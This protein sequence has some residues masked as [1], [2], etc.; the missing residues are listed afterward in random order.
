MKVTNTLDLSQNK[1]VNLTDGVDD[2]D[3]ASVA[4][5][6]RAV[7]GYKYKEPVRVAT[8][9]SI[10]LSG[11][12][13]ID[14]VSVSAGDRVLVKDQTDAKENGVYIANS[15]VWS[16]S[17][18]FSNGGD[19]LG[20]AVFVSEGSDNGNDLYL[21]TTDAPVT[22]DTTDLV[23]TQIGGGI[24][25]TPG[26][27]INFDGTTIEIDRSLV[28]TKA[29]FNIG[30]AVATSFTVTHNFGTRDVVVSVRDNGTYAGVIA[31]WVALDVNSVQ[32]TFSRA[33]SA[34]QYRVIVMG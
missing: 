10:T 2:Q 22:V 4:Q 32:I 33:P 26:T 11:T 25:Y 5:L 9:E 31:D 16:R 7:K 13:V 8:T 34:A 18:D 6:N 12:Q 27:G 24:S 28:S 19:I 15:S 3:A 20:A 1:I 30:D 29:S 23:F 21:M 17:A 14:G